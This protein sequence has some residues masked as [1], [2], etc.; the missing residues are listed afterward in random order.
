M[1]KDKT[2]PLTKKEMDEL[3]DE[4]LRPLTSR[5]ATKETRLAMAMK[6]ATNLT[7]ALKGEKPLDLLNPETYKKK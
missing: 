4:V 5:N 1:N 2:Q 3:F 6:A 7:M